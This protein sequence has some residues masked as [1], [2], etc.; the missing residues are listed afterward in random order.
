M[1]HLFSCSFSETVPKAAFDKSESR[2][3]MLQVFNVDTHS[4]KQLR[5]FKFLSVSF[6][7]QLLASS[8]FIRKVICSLNVFVTVV[9]CFLKE[10]CFKLIKRA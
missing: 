9:L 10:L 1:G 3:E 8:H 5:H 6:M 7:S 2:E 4:S